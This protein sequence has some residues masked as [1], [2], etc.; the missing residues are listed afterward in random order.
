MADCKFNLD[1]TSLKF[2]DSQ[3]LHEEFNSFFRCQFPK[4]ADFLQIFIISSFQSPNFTLQNKAENQFD[5]FVTENYEI[6][7]SRSHVKTF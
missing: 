7:F 3:R 4:S 1:F 6:I 5:N 2:V